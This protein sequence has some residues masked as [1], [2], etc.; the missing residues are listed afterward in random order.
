MKK[1]LGILLIL[2]MTTSVFSEET[3]PFRKYYDNGKLQITGN[4]LQKTGTKHGEWTYYFENGKLMRTEKYEDGKIISK[5]GLTRFEKVFEKEELGWNFQTLKG[6]GFIDEN[7]KKS[8]DWKFYGESG[9][10]RRIGSYKDGQKVGEWKYYHDNGKLKEIGSYEAGKQEIE[11]KRYSEN[12]VSKS[13]SSDNDRKKEVN[14]ADPIQRMQMS[15]EIMKALVRISSNYDRNKV[16]QW[17][18]YNKNGELSG[19]SFWKDGKRTRKGEWK[20]YHNGKLRETGSYKLGKR[21]GEWKSYHDNGKLSEIVSYKDGKKEGEWKSY[22]DNG[23]LAQIVFYKD[24]KI[25]EGWSTPMEEE[26]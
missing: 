2:F 26:E 9:D 21:E 16:G 6:V 11:D 5:K 12:D 15:M 23:K 7:G 24:G 1:L 13:I 3:T 10:L 4:K 18:F 22:Y 17:K 25:E 19:I 8:G 20:F 14:W